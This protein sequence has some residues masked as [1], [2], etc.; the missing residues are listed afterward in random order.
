MCD[1]MVDLADSDFPW[2]SHEKSAVCLHCIAEGILRGHVENYASMNLTQ[3]LDDYLL[4]DNPI[5][6]NFIFHHWTGHMTC[7]ECKMS[8]S[9]NFNSEQKTKIISIIREDI[10]CFSNTLSS[11]L[12]D[13][14]QDKNLEIQRLEQEL[15]EYKAELADFF[16]N[17]KNVQ[18]E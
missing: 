9:P 16:I 1:N 5:L 10:S 2:H 15:K 8:Y 11:I 3:T 12:I 6:P 7:M 18:E 13:V 17:L 14:I 4:E